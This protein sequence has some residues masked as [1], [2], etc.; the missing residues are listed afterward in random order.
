MKLRITIESKTFDV[1]VEVLEGGPATPLPV[2]PRPAAVASS[3]PRAV[4]SSSPVS[5]GP[6]AAP[7]AGGGKV[8]PSPLSGTVRAVKVKPGD[9]VAANAEVLVLEA[10]KMETSVYAPS[11]GTVKAVLVKEGDTVQA[12]TGLLEFA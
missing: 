6:A 12:G 4:S 2:A 8:F 1:E 9:T 11:A 7:A 3:A 10:M 5:S